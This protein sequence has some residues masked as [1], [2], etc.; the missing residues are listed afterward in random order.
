MAEPFDL[1][2]AAIIDLTQRIGPRTPTWPG[3]GEVEV[4][5]TATVPDDGY[6]ARRVTMPEHVATH[7]DAPAHVPHGAGTV[8]DIPPGRLVRPAAVIDV[9]HVVGDDPDA[10]IGVDAIAES[11]SVHGVLEIGDVVL[12][13]TGWDRHA[14]DAAAYIGAGEARCPGLDLAAAEH[15]IRRGVV[16]IGIDTLSVEAGASED[17]AVHHRTLGAGLWHAE[18]LVGLDRVPA[19][20]AWIVVAPLRLAGGSGAPARVLA[21]VP[22]GA[23]A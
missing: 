1:S 6:L 9:R 4:E 13:R 23:G 12:I 11:E 22:P 5:V 21:L 8:D 7:V 14:D 10:V 16:G 18:G 2:W 3:D 17:L 19:R 20:G 15:L